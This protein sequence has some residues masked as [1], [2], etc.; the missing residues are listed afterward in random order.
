MTSR[1]KILDDLA[2]LAGG[3]VG[4]AHDTKARVSD[5]IRTGVD[6]VAQ[7]LDLVPREDFERLETMLFKAIERIEAL[8]M[9]IKK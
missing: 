2:Q 3:A 7:D 6:S 1:E 8:E 5:I 4:I 9:Q